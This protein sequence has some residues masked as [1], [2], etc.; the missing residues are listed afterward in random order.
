MHRPP[1]QGSHSQKGEQRWRD[2]VTVVPSSV[3]LVASVV[4]RFIGVEAWL[5]LPA[6]GT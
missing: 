1:G 6:G 4:L 2:R 5:S 3:V